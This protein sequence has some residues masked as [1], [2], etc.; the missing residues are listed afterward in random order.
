MSN[1][2]KVG[3]DL[4]EKASVPKP[5]KAVVKIK[6]EK[7]ARETVRTRLRRIKAAPGKAPASRKLEN[8][9]DHKSLGAAL[10]SKD[11]GG[12]TQMA[13]AEIE[14]LNAEDLKLI[15]EFSIL[16]GITNYLTYASS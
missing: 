7:S 14:R 15:R 5:E 8:V 11:Q 4:S 13:K 10:R 3:Y 2:R 1:P 6:E 9:A 16:R 12:L